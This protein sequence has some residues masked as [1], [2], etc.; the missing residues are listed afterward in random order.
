M[1]SPQG[2]QML[3]AEKNIESPRSLFHYSKESFPI[4][5]IVL[6]LMLGVLLFEMQYNMP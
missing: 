1:Y 2:S 6:F 4:R 3:K 5:L